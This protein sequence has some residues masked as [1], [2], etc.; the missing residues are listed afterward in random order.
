MRV[1]CNTVD[2][3]IEFT[4]MVQDKMVLFLVSVWLIWKMGSMVEYMHQVPNLTH[5]SWLYKGRLRQ[6]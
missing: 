1:I 3:L 2:V 5:N 6:T 4:L